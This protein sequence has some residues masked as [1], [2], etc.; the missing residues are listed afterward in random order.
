MSIA[1]TVQAIHCIKNTLGEINR[2]ETASPVKFSKQEKQNMITY[3]IIE[4]EMMVDT[5]IERLII[6]MI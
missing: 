5:N 4:K 1:K 3:A 2:I 6:Q